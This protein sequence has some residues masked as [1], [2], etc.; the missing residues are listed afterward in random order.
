MD[1][2]VGE[3]KK[4]TEK[5]RKVKVE[6]AEEAVPPKKEK[7]PTLE[8]SPDLDIRSS[9]NLEE[10]S[11]KLFENLEVLLQTPKGNPVLEA[12]PN[13]LRSP[14]AVMMGEMM[15]TPMDST[16]FSSVVAE[17]DEF[18]NLG[19]EIIHFIDKTNVFD[20]NAAAEPANNTSLSVSYQEENMMLKHFFKKLLPLLDAH[21]QSPWPDLA[22]KYCDFDV[23]RS[24]FISL[25]CIHIYESRK[26][27]NEYYKKGMAHIN[28]TMNYL[29]KFISNLE[30]T[31]D[32]EKL[33]EKKQIQSFVILVLINVHILFAVLEKG[34]SSL[35]RFLFKVFGS[36]CQDSEF[37]ETLMEN[38]SKRSLVVVLS[39]YDTV[40]A[41]VSPDCRLPFCNPEWYGSHTDNIS[42]AKMMGCPG[43]IFRAMARV[44]FL[45]HEA[46]KGLAINESVLQ[47]FT[48]IKQDLLRYRDYVDFNQEDYT[49]RLKGAQCWALAVYISLLRVVDAKSDIKAAVHEFI[50]V[51]SSMPSQSP[52]VTQM[53]WPV[54]AVGCE[55][56]TEFEQ[57]KLHEFMSTLYETAQMGTLFSLRWVV[58]QVWELGK[59]QEEVLEEWLDKGVDYLP[60]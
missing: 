18:T 53:V 45:R 48:N 9:R 12:P 5:K 54:Y 50:D 40:S 55:C 24:C 2:N 21:P 51:Y 34:R 44:C 13:D 31:E 22:L 26:G 59:T 42:T 39:W 52:I 19:H 8:K 36:V 16:P 30:S 58:E 47:E 4:K 43:E 15:P 32:S 10:F 11:T 29:I 56:T 57:E 60:L 41:I 35:S 37:Y 33:N 1:G 49:L 14:L 46:Y 38:E 3:L 23:A 27:G 7:I 20:K 17:N 28:S 25:A 6:Q